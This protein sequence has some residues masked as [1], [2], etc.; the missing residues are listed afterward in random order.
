MT[1]SSEVQILP[2]VES[3]DP[4][5]LQKLGGRKFTL[6]LLC[7]AVTSVLCWFGKIDQGIYSVVAVSLVGGY[8][9]GNVVQ[10]IALQPK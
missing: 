7:F 9:T 4:T 3:T 1:D 5:N 2:V 10:K 6:V 8:I